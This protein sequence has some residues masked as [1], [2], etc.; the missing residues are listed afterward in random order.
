[1]KSPLPPRDRA[2]ARRW[3]A[4]LACGAALL[5]GCASRPVRLGTSDRWPSLLASADEEASA[6]CYLCLSRA[7]ATYEAGLARGKDEAGKRAY[8]TAVHLAVRERLLGLYPGDYQTAPARLAAHGHPDD[9][10][11]AEDALPAIAWRRGTLGV[12][13]SLPSPAADLARWRARRVALEAVADRDAWAATLLLAMVATNPSVAVAEGQ[14]PTRG[15][16]P[17]LDRDTWWGRHPDDPSLSFTRLTLLQGSMDDLVAFRAARQSFE[18]VDALIGEAELTRGRLVSADEALGRALVPFPSLVPALALRGDLRQRMEDYPT[19]LTMYDALLARLPEHREAL[20]GRLKSLGFVSRHQDAIAAADRMIALGTWYIGE[21]QY[22]KAWN[23]FSLG[24]IDAARRSVDAA[25]P[26]MVNADVS[27]LGGV[28]A[29]RQ[30]RGDDA[31]RDFDTAIDLEGRHCEAHF[32]RAALRLTRKEWPAAASGFD[33]AFECLD[34]RLP[35]LEQR[36]VDARE[37]R[38]DDDARAALVSR[39]EQAIREHRHQMAWARCNGGVAYANA[40]QASR[41]RAMADEAIAIGGP[42]SEAA[43]RLLDQ[44]PM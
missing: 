2:T 11:T 14:P 30:Q 15:P 42:A 19:A 10:V 20:L 35:V 8:R 4:L 1:M 22:W 5:A 25:R 28:I 39:R 27:Y 36:I 7:L 31:L 44:L 40:G 26:L 23:E 32:D 24:Q 33:E 29:F 34:G 37:A 18:E 9:V 38:L 17:W 41:A 13:V 12:G 6:G 43:R 3:L 16:W 21:A